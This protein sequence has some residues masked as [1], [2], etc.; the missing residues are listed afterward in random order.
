VRRIIAA[1]TAPR[2]AMPNPSTPPRAM[3]DSAA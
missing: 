2:R 1:A 3:S